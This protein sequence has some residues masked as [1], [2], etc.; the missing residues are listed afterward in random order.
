MCQ[1]ILTAKR[2]TVKPDYN[3]IFLGGRQKLKR[4]IKSYNKDMCLI[5]SMSL[6]LTAHMPVKLFKL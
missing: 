3:P 6:E 2:S 5:S 1:A 4:E